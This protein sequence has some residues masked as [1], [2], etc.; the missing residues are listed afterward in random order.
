MTAKAPTPMPEGINRPKAPA[1][2]L[3]RVGCNRHPC[4]LCGTVLG[5]IGAYLH[6]IGK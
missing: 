6:L 1:A 3:I 4:P 2:P 5:S